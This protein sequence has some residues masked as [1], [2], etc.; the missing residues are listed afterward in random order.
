M[1]GVSPCIQAAC[2]HT[3]Q[4]Q[5]QRQKVVDA[6]KAGKLDVLLVS[7][8]AVVSGERASGFGSILKELP[9]IAFACIDEAHCVSHWSHNFRPSYLVICKVI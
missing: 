9:N 6:A 8:E 5:Q 3:N 1:T 7:P 2:L 4:T